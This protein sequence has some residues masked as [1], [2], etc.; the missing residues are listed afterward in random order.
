M[1][2]KLLVLAVAVGCVGLS[3]HLLLLDWVRT[4]LSPTPPFPPHA[5][6]RAGE[7]VPTLG[8]EAS[9]APP[10][11]GR[12]QP[13]P[14]AARAEV[15]FERGGFDSAENIYLFAVAAA[16][17]SNPTA[18]TQ[19]LH[20]TLNCLSIR[21]EE[22]NYRRLAS[23]PAEPQVSEARSAAAKSLLSRC[24]GFLSN[25]E[26]A[27]TGLRTRITSKLRASQEYVMGVTDGAAS[28]A[29]LRSIITRGDYLSFEKTMIDVLPR[30]LNARNDSLTAERERD[31]SLAYVLASCDLGRDCSPRS[32]TYSMLCARDGRCEGSLEEFYLTGL[33]A[34]SRANVA[35]LRAEVVEAF[36]SR[37]L[38]YFGL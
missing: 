35:V 37:N 29:Q 28:E 18:L 4:P 8:S 38:K 14:K 7:A 9:Y 6:H 23:Q 27:A 11:D 19:A 1:R 30:V 10:L 33:D 3:V 17:S 25:D 36:R 15:P 16:D 24:D 5:S 34:R 26:A 22:A 21:K 31:L 32:M 2:R 20:A 12:A 13:L